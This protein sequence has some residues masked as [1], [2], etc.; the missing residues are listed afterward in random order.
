MV[1]S[2]YITY[3][4]YNMLWHLF[5]LFRRKKKLILYCEDAIDII[6]FKNV[7]KYLE[8][9]DIVA[10]NNEIKQ[11]LLNH[12]YKNISIMP[13][14]PDVVI[15]FRNMAWKFPCKKIIKIGFTHGAYNFKKHSKANYYNMFDLFF[16]TSKHDIEKLRK[17]GVTIDLD[18]AYPKIDSLFNGVEK[19]DIQ[20]DHEKKTL[21]FA[22]T[23]DKSGMSAIDKWIDKISLLKDKFNLIV[24][25]HEWMSEE[26]KIKLRTNPDIHFI[27]ELDRLKYIPLADICINDMSSIIAECCLLDKPIITF[28]VP[29]TSRTMPEIINMIEN[30]S[31]RIDDFDELENAVNILLENQEMFKEERKKISNILFHNPDG[32]SGQ[33]AALKIK[34]LIESLTH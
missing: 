4:F 11:K 8:N 19:P 25:V 2:Y 9:I 17:H 24:T 12:G 16:L 6:L 21:F 29:N 28:K 5:K 33:R 22:S 18:I 20:L 13:S 7:G 15:M 30:I 14:F 27:E 26:Y 23:Y 1:F 34:N 31:L 32:K 10:K 3:P